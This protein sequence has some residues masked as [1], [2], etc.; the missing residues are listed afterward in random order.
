MDPFLA[1]RGRQVTL[2]EMREEV[3]AGLDMLPTAM[4]L[5]RLAAADVKIETRTR[6]TRLSRDAAV[7][8][9]D[10]GE[11]RIPVETVVLAVGLRR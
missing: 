4:L 10:G 6:V 3:G 9:R 8:E 11:A 2:V 5:Q 7:V 1:A